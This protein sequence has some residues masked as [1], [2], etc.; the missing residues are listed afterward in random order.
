MAHQIEIKE[1]INGIQIT[2]ILEGD[3]SVKFISF[4][5]Q[6]FFRSTNESDEESYQVLDRLGEIYHLPALATEFILIDLN[7]TVYIPSDG[8]E[9]IEYSVKLRPFR[10]ENDIDKVLSLGEIETTAN[11]VTIEMPIDGTNSVMIGGSIYETYYPSNFNFVPVVSDQKIII[12]YAKPDAQ[13]F[14]LAQGI[15][16]VEAIEPNYDGLFV[17]RIIVNSDGQIIEEEENVYKTIASDAWRLFTIATATPFNIVMGSSLAGSFEIQS[18]VSSP[19]LGIISSKYGV[20]LWDGNEF[21][22]KNVSAYD[23]TLEPT[24]Y[25]DTVNFKSISFAETSIVKSGN[26]AKLKIKAGVLE[27]I[28]MGSDVDLTPY[29]LDADLDAEIVNRAAADANL[30]TQV[31]TNATAIST[32]TS[33]RITAIT[34]EANARIL[35]DSIETVIIVLSPIDED[36]TDNIARKGFIATFPFQ[37]LSFQTTAYPVP[38][39]SG[40]TTQLRKNGTVI[41]TTHS[42]IAANA[43]NSTAS[44]APVFSSDTF[45]IGDRLDFFTPSGGIGSTIKGQNL[46]SILIIQKL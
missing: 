46:K 18:T 21:W 28:E 10:P 9:L 27:V 43:N 13:V 37:I 30:Q 36:L 39:G 29:A 1:L 24:A 35:G 7:D 42:V 2:E 3:T 17:A 12:L 14:Y 38:T 31:N 33:N 32:E 45:A 5:S 23:L 4:Q 40:I 26:W 25:T 20:A 15:E 34:T 6:P 41:T 44:S 11:S 16:A 22:I 8:A 19:V